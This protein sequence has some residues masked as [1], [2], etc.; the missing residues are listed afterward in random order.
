MNGDYDGGTGKSP[1]LSNPTSSSS[2]RRSSEYGDESEDVDLGESGRSSST[3]HYRNRNDSN[4]L[5][6]QPPPCFSS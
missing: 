4:G 1:T 5:S 3:I 6:L 2:R